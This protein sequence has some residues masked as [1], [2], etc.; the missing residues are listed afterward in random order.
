MTTPSPSFLA[1]LPIHDNNRSG[2]ASKQHQ[3]LA[4]E[5]TTNLA[6][7]SNSQRHSSTIP[8]PPTAPFPS[9]LFPS[10]HGYLSQRVMDK[11]GRI[12][13]SYKTIYNTHSRGPGRKSPS[14]FTYPRQCF[15]YKLSIITPKTYEAKAP[16]YCEWGGVRHDAWQLTFQ[17]GFLLFFP[18][19]HDFPSF[20]PFPYYVCT[21]RL[22]NGMPKLP[23][24]IRRHADRRY[25]WVFFTSHVR[26]RQVV[27]RGSHGS[28]LP[29][30][31]PT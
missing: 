2:P 15:L 22:E 4:S 14:I 1:N 6:M 25:V 11:A 10:C 20:N 31:F 8:N 28:Y 7:D 24:C 16:S 12:F 29:T 18:P 27:T 23:P 17:S 3:G 21:N 5:A 19:L 13:R 30:F 26:P 9:F